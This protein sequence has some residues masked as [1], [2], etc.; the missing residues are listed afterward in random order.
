M[1]DKLETELR[2]AIRSQAESVSPADRLGAIRAR[3][4]GESSSTRMAWWNRPWVLAAG[5]GLVAAS[6]I[7]AAMVLA[8]PSAEELPVAGTQREVTVYEV[9]E[10]GDREWLF[11]QQVFTEDTGDLAFDAVRA[12]LQHEPTQDARYNMLAEC[13][14]GGDVSSVEASASRVVVELSPF[15]PG[16]AVC[17]MSPMGAAARM[18]QMVWTVHQATAS[19]LPVQVTVAGD[20]TEPPVDVDPQALSPIIIESPTDGATVASP[21]TISG[22]SDTFEGNVVWEVVSDDA[23]VAKGGH[24]MGGTMGERAPFEFTVDLPPG[25]Y[26]ARAYAEDMETGGLFAEDRVTFTVE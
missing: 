3:T 1:N 25:S 21:V 9:G 2:S 16:A 8:D 14:L 13:P 18:Q 19:E 12:L 23:G 7:T 22:T 5:T 4:R 6:V 26:T 15:P 24:T 20:P 10:V 11:P 17:D